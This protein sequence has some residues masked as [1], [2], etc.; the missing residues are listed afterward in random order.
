MGSGRLPPIYNR[1]APS[2]RVVPPPFAAPEFTFNVSRLYFPGW[3]IPGSVVAHC[4]AVVVLT[5]LTSGAIPREEFQRERKQAEID[6]E[7]NFQEIMYLPLT[8]SGSEGEEGAPSTEEA[9]LAALSGRE[10]LVYPGPQTIISDPPDPTNQIQTLLQPDLPELPILPPPLSLPNLIRTA[11]AGPRPEANPPPAEVEAEEPFPEPENE[12]AA[13]FRPDRPRSEPGPP[14]RLPEAEIPEPSAEPDLSST[15]ALDVTT[16]INEPFRQPRVN[17][18]PPSILELPPRLEARL[19]EVALT[20][21]PIHPRDPVYLPLKARAGSFP[22]P[23]TADETDPSPEP[24]EEE[25]GSRIAEVSSEVAREEAPIEQAAGEAAAVDGSQ[26][27]ESGAGT[28]SSGSEGPASPPAEEFSLLPRPGND[29]Q[30]LLALTPLPARAE[31]QIMIPLGETRGRFAISPEPNLSAA[32]SEPGTAAEGPSESEDLSLQP[33]GPGADSGAGKPAVVNISFGSN[34]SASGTGDSGTGAGSGGEGN[35]G[36]T[37]SSVSGSGGGSGF[38]AGTVSGSGSGNN[39]FPGIQ[40]IGGFGDSGAAAHSLPATSVRRP[41]Q[42]EY[43]LFIISTED[44]GGGLPSFGVFSDEQ[45]YTVYLDMRETETDDPVQWTIE[46]AA[47][48][49]DDETD[50]EPAAT[51]DADERGL[52]LPFPRAKKAPEFPSEALREHDREILIVYTVIDQD[53]ELRDLEV[54]QSPDPRLDSIILDTLQNWE[55]RP[56]LLNGSV[57]DVKA[58]IGI[59]LEAP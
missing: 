6:S 3:G 29:S 58:L 41:L 16:A 13:D 23:G 21:L 12:V 59:P 38:G 47:I 45:V 39:P 28:A 52:V 7:E 35:P 55:F 15:A 32:D 30:N 14:L 40:V 57:V 1:L 33:A 34:G 51:L 44:S 53:G 10:G 9:V 22:E 24:T 19:A 8:G 37:G 2:R 17:P 54:K 5:L 43:G 48:R 31:G 46:F 49:N 26:S 27:A 42:T 56:A 11:P 20:R 4:A 25:N 36:G 18:L 50:R